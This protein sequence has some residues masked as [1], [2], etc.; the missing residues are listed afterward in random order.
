MGW[1]T[2][3]LDISIFEKTSGGATYREKR[4]VYCT[5]C[6]QPIGSVST[7]IYD[8]G[9]KHYCS[10]CYSKTIGSEAVE[11]DHDDIKRENEALK[12]VK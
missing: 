4:I 6:N 11:R 2:E 7:S 10:K 12:I 3:F 8:I 5:G 9:E 1:D